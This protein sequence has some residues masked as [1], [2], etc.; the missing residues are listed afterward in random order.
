MSIPL[1]PRGQQH[2]SDADTAPFLP[3]P[4]LARPRSSPF[5]HRR[6][7]VFLL[8]TLPALVL[9]FLATAGWGQ[10][11]G[12]GREWRKEVVAERISEGLTGLRQSWEGVKTWGWRGDRVHDDAVEVAEAE[13]EEQAEEGDGPIKVDMLPSSLA[14]EHAYD[15]DERFL[16]YLPHSG[17]HN[18][19]SALVNALYLGALL[20]RTVLVPPIWAG[21][22]P[23]SDFYEDLQQAWTSQVGMHPASFLLPPSSS[24]NTT[25]LPFNSLTSPDPLFHPA[26][27]PSTY[28]DFPSRT[29]DPPATH[30]QKLADLRASKAAV[31]RAKGYEMRPDGYPDVPGM[32][33]EDCKSKK[34]ECRNLVQDTWLA[35]DKVVDLR[36]VVAAGAVKVLDRWDMRE[37]AVE[38]LVNVTKEDVLVFQDEEPYDFQ[39]ADHPIPDDASTPPLVTESTDDS[40]F[41]RIVSV[42]AMRELPQRLFLIGSM[43][44]YER[45]VPYTPSWV[46]SPADNGIYDPSTSPLTDLHKHLTLSLAFSSAEI[47]RPAR[48]IRNLLGGTQAY[49]GAHARI[50]DGVFGKNKEENMHELWDKLA[51]RLGVGKATRKKLLAT[52][53]DDSPLAASSAPIE[54]PAHLVAANL[55]CHAPLHKT[56]SRLALN[57][58]L[59]LATDS[60]SPFTDPALR[61]FYHTFPCVFL[62]S[63][64]AHLPSVE[65]MGTLVNRVDGV[66]LGRLFT[67]FLEATVASMGKE[68]VGTKGSTFSG[69]AETT[70]HH[71]FARPP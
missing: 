24:D 13:A 3:R 10:G 15:P 37:R 6:G 39:F 30:R 55:T 65:R 59:F 27:Y 26:S 22:A 50:G 60:P 5:T 18:Q 44:G 34:D 38:K 35:W 25:S 19:R 69:Y 61:I 45:V 11:D 12:L 7:R 52:A 54:T 40:H 64:F 62:L 70:L 21:W 71:A 9:V 41:K 49:V 43:F 17:F 48:E 47:L 1:L 56:K 16:G 29:A 57:T 32:K 42:A 36:K 66:P 51:G 63:D 20:N 4:V 67:P 53:A 8:V 31:W 68:I 2:D 28:T 14:K 46:S 33:P 23:A 58:P